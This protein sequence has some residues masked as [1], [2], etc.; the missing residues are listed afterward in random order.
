MCEI[1]HLINNYMVN[2]HVGEKKPTPKGKTEC[3]SIGHG[4]LPRDNK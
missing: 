2:S 4:I 3:L 1:H